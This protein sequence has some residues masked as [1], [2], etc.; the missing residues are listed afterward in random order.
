GRPAVL[1]AFQNRFRRAY[2]LGTTLADAATPICHG[3]FPSAKDA[4]AGM[5]RC[6][7]AA[8]FTGEKFGRAK[9]PEEE[10]ARTIRRPGRPACLDGSDL[11]GP[12]IQSARGPPCGLS[13]RSPGMGESNRLGAEERTNRGR[14][15]LQKNHRPRTESANKK[16]TALPSMR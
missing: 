4:T 10:S 9:L 16:V 1:E 13:R 6:K 12:G 5:L 15:R 8:A 14:D 11:D 3:R 7:N 2:G